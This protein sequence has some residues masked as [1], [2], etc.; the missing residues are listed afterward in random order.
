[1]N[2][3]PTEKST[4]DAQRSS[5]K[6]RAAAG[7]TALHVDCLMLNVERFGLGGKGVFSSTRRPVSNLFHLGEVA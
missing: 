1:M 5:S 3:Q 4:S 7:G 2:T 6:R